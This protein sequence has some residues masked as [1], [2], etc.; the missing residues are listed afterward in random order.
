[1]LYAA[2]ELRREDTIA[3]MEEEA[4]AMVRWDRFP[5]LLEGPLHC[6]MGRYI[7]VEDTPCRV[8]HEHKHIEDAKGR[9]DYH[10]EI[11][12][13]DSLGM[14]AHK[15]LPS[16]RRRAFPSPRVQARGQILAY[17]AW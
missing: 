10:T 14:I 16:L 12:G 2:V 6:G 4:I 1:V 11:T 5:E 3:I 15:G 8:F 17:R 7:D 9:R 13:D